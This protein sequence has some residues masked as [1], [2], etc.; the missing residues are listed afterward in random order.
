[1]PLP[2]DAKQGKAVAILWWLPPRFPPI[3]SFLGRRF[4]H[5]RAST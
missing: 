2:E 4:A 1:M 3:Y 5:L